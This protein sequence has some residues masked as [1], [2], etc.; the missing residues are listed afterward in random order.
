E[1]H[2]DIAIVGGGPVGMTLALALSRSMAG[3]KIAMLDRRDFAVPQ[4][5]R[6]FAISAGVKRVL[7]TLG[8]WRAVADKAEPILKMKITD[9]G[10]GDIARPLFLSF[11]GPLSSGEPYAHMVPNTALSA[12]LLK[13]LEGR[14]TLLSKVEVTGFEAD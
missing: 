4:D 3:L 11:E 5:Q 14:A 12:A 2:H 6:A 8:V 7:E 10:T 13:T 9:S 1:E